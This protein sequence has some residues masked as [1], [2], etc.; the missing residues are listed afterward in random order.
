M[1][2]QTHRWRLIAGVFLVLVMLEH[3]HSTISLLL[4]GLGLFFRCGG[5]ELYS[6]LQN[7]IKFLLNSFN[8]LFKSSISKFVLR[9]RRVVLMEILKLI[10]NVWGGQCRITV[11][12][13]AT[14]VR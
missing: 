9:I 12:L 5:A 1:A 11:I 4:G 6:M 14:F 10:I 7:P 13:S 2:D 8:L 3:P